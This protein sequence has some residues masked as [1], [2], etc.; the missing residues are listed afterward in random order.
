MFPCEVE[1]RLLI[2]RLGN[3]QAIVS[4]AWTQLRPLPSNLDQPVR[5]SCAFYLM[6]L[7]TMG[8]KL[9]NQ[10]ADASASDGCIRRGLGNLADASAILTLLKRHTNS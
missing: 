3:I 2:I 7:S 5:A 9:L 10:V 1:S 8:D 4:I 6:S